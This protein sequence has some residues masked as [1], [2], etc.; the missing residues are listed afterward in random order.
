[1][2]NTKKLYL[3]NYYVYKIQCRKS[4]PCCGGDA[5]HAHSKVK[6]HLDLSVPQLVKSN[7]FYPYTFIRILLNSFELNRT[8]KHCNI[9]TNRYNPPQ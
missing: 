1:M 7:T 6:C 8:H 3:I 4:R 2:D 5:M 9:I